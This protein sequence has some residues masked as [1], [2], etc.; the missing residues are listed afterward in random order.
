MGKVKSELFDWE[1][2]D[3]D[4]WAEYQETMNDPEMIEWQRENF[5]KSVEQ[6]GEE[7]EKRNDRK[8]H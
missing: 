6:Q 2:E 3:S 5:K 8:N 1:H 7:M 4:H